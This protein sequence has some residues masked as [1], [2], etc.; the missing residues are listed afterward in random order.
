MMA[1]GLLTMLET[2][3]GNQD[4]PDDKTLIQQAVDLCTQ[5]NL[6]SDRVEKDLNLFATNSER[7]EQAVELMEETLASDR[8]KRE[9]RQGEKAEAT[10]S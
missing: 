4:T 8:R 6:P 1:I 7:M 5:L 10:S 2:A 3:R 9:Q